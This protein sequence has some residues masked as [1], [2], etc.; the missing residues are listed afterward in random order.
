MKI[1]KRCVY[2][3]TNYNLLPAVLLTPLYSMTTYEPPVVARKM[4]APTS[5]YVPGKCP[6]VE[7]Y[8]LRRGF[9]LAFKFLHFHAG[10]EV[11]YGS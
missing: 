5:E 6:K 4:F 10:I 7:T 11:H 1:V 8:W 9:R 2:L 3:G